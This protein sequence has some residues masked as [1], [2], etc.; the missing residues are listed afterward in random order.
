[1]NKRC[2]T[3][4]E[5]TLEIYRRENGEFIATVSHFFRGRANRKVA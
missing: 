3:R 2:K 5:L 1:M 4:E